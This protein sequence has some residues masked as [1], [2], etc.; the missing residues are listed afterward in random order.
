MS[1]NNRGTTLVFEL[2]SILEKAWLVFCVLCWVDMKKCSYCSFHDVKGRSFRAS[3]SSAWPSWSS[4]RTAICTRRTKTL[5]PKCRRLVKGD[6]NEKFVYRKSKSIRVVQARP[7]GITIT[8]SRTISCEWPN[9]WRPKNEKTRPSSKKS[10][11]RSKRNRKLKIRK[12][13]RRNQW[14]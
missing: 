12:L 7:V 14:R 9:H 4:E 10:S 13:R 5:R 3:S 1:K 11:R 8:K 6:N 2:K